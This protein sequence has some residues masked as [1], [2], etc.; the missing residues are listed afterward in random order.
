MRRERIVP[1]APPA[2]SAAT[3]RVMQG[4]AR[5]E[6]SPERYLRSALHGQGLRFRKNFSP[7]PG[8]RCR[9]D[10]V[11]TAARLAVFV[12]GCFWHS[13]PAHGNAP[14]TNGDWWRRKLAANVERDHRNTAQLTEAGWTVLRLW[15]HEPVPTMVDRVT[16]AL[17]T[18]ALRPL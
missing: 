1:V 3:R 13:C 17:R 18:A 6:T 5:A 12:D 15:E 9:V 14:R 7:V 2:S 10:V 8:M 4:N 16:D 11:F